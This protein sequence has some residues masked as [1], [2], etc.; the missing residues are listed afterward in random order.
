[1]ILFP[2]IATKKMGIQNSISFF[3]FFL[4]FFLFSL[5]NRTNGS[6]GVVYVVLSTVLDESLK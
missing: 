6:S 4:S 3:S 1:M 2:I 5:L